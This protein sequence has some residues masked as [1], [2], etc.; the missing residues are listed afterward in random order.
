MV[1]VRLKTLS[2]PDT[3]ILANKILVTILL[4]VFYIHYLSRYLKLA[5]RVNIK[6]YLEQPVGHVV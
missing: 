5:F 4:F 1:K 2:V 3:Y 6:F